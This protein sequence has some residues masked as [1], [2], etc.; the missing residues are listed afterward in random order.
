MNRDWD[1]FSNWGILFTQLVQ[2]FLIKAAEQ[3]PPQK[4]NEGVSRLVIDME[5]Q[6]GSVRI[7]VLF[8]PQWEEG[9]IEDVLVKALEE[10]WCYKKIVWTVDSYDVTDYYDE[11]L[12]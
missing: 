9:G 3:K 12:L 10:L 4:R 2:L 11:K 1:F 8:S 5:K 6:T 7:A